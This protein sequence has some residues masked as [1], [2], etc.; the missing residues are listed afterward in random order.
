MLTTT[1]LAAALT[2]ASLPLLAGGPLPAL[3]PDF[4]DAEKLI[5]SF[6]TAALIGIV[7][8]VFIETGL[9][10]P[11]L[12]GDS[13]LFTAGALVAQDSL[14]LNIWVLCL[15]L[16]LAAFTGDQVAYAIGRKLGPRVFSRPDSRFFKQK[17]IDQTYAYFDKYGGRTIIVARFVPFVRTYAPVAAGV[18]K[19]SYRHFVSYNVVGALLWGVGVTLLGYWLGNFS[20]IKNNIE[21]LLILIVGV[22]VLP[23]VFE[24]WKARRK[25]ETGETV[26]GRDTDFDEP[27]ERAA[28]EREVFGH[29]A[30]PPVPGQAGTEVVDG[31]PDAGG[32]ADR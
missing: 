24:L 8:V 14:Q 29:A 21:A 1:A 3:G 19:M 23:V 4:L 28:V 2:D 5:E 10:F 22:S 17:Y 26:E 27:V 18:G 20:F 7:A 13:L 16:F 25:E 11:F 6:G 12:P 31:A 9:L 30:T 32:R 15:L